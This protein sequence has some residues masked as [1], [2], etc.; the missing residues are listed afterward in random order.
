[1]IDL[2]IIIVS[3]NNKEKLRVTL[4]AVYKSKTKYSYEVIVVDNDSKD[5]SVEMVENQFPTAKVIRNANN[6]FSKGNNVGLDASEGE[7]ILFLN[8]DTAVEENVIE[9]CLTKIQ[10]DSEIGFLTCRLVKEDGLP[11]LAARRSFPNPVNALARFTYLD[12]IFPT[13]FGGY[14][15]RAVSDQSEHQVDAMAGAFMM[16]RREV[17]EKIGQWDEEF[18][19]YGED[20]EYC[21][22]AKQA[23]Y[24]NIY[25]PKVTTRHFKGQSSKKTPYFSLYHFHN[26]MWIFYRKHYKSKYP[27]FV[28]WMVWSGI[29][30]RFYALVVV[31]K[32]R[33]NPYVSK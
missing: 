32:F 23:G 2:S 1:M 26:A 25:F 16:V 29:W 28:N 12:K 33:T 17:L 19:M 4:D 7:V 27:F 18:F 9:E 6:G 21:Y 11:D 31:N 24:K 5:N 14:N 15:M 3:Y 13:K 30:L 8:P 22:R 20:I 10:S